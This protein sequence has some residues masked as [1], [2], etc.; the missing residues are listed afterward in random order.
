M[1]SVSEKI[2]AEHF[3][4]THHQ[5]EKRR[6][7][8]PL[9]LRSDAVPLGESRTMAVKRFKMLEA[10]LRAK[11][12]FREFA[13]CIDEYFKLG[14]VEPVPTEEIFKKSYNMPMYAARKDSSTTTKIRVVFDASVKSTSGS[15]LNDQFLV[16]PTVHASLI[17]ILIRFRRHKVAMAADVSKMNRAVLLSEDQW[18]LHRF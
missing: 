2:V 5:D 10:S 13:E 15:S 9:P 16:G 18:D 4:R 6:F 14:H 12:Q 17:D 1:L 7:V 11:A 3:K 8:I